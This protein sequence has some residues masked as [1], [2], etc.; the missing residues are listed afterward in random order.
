MIVEIEQMKISLI[1]TL[2]SLAPH[3]DEIAKEDHQCC[4]PN[5]LSVISLKN[6]LSDV[7]MSSSRYTRKWH[8][9]GWRNFPILLC[10]NHVSEYDSFPIKYLHGKHLQRLQDF[11]N[12]LMVISD[13]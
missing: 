6:N 13:L 2:I 3:I 12:S 10:K 11:Y 9:S 7:V 1:E 5:P 8:P 4:P